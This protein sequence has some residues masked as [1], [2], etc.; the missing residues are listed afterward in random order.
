MQ[1]FLTM[2]TMCVALGFNFSLCNR[3]PSKPCEI[4]ATAATRIGECKYS[5]SD[6]AP[7]IVNLSIPACFREPPKSAP[8]WAHRWYHKMLPVSGRLPYHFIASSTDETNLARVLMEKRRGLGLGL[9]SHCLGSDPCC[10][11]AAESQGSI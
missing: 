1:T 4:C 3:K 11:L 7:G 10:G 9:Q 6:R 8:T 2:Q 5:K